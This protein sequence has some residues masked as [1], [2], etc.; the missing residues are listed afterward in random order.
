MAYQQR[1][2]SPLDTWSC[3][4]WD[5]HM[6]LYWDQSLKKLIMFRTSI[7][8]WY[9]YLYFTSI[10]LKLTQ[11]WRSEFEK[12]Q[13]ESQ[14]AKS[15]KDTAVRENLS[16]QLEHKQ[17]P[18]KGR[19]QVSGRVRLPCWHATPVTKC[20]F[21]E[22]IRNSVTVKLGINVMKSVKSL[23]GWESL[24]LVVDQ[25]V[26]SHSREGDFMLQN[27]ILVSTINLS[28][29]RVSSVQRCMPVWVVY[30]KF[31]WPFHKTFIWGASLGV[32]YKL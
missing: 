18:R 4:I 7:I 16:Q 20:S 23:I 32:L 5:L 1:T 15:K 2:L 26:T 28:W 31:A 30:W 3:P 6:F 10:L 12:V 14:G 29:I 22:T 13:R 8:N 27:K 24:L 11:V 21:M 17:V 25:N 9:F 19:N